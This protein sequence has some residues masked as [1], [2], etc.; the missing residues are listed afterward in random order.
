MNDIDGI[1]DHAR[2]MVAEAKDDIVIRLR[3]KA[4][5]GGV[6]PINDMTLL[7]AA[8]CIEQLRMPHT[9]VLKLAELDEGADAHAMIKA[10]CKK[11]EA[12]RRE[13]A[14]LN[15]ARHDER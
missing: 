4:S 11:V 14:K 3:R 12:Q 6:I 7:A 9:E 1:G 8:D 2:R 10:L 13:I 15:E 5:R